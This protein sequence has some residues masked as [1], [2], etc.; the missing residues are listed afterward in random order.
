MSAEARQ[1][2]FAGVTAPSKE[3]SP[4]E[5]PVILPP[6]PS[7]WSQVSFSY[8]HPGVIWSRE[9]MLAAGSAAAVG[10]I[11]LLKRSFSAN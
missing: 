2:T 5:T 10:V 4:E 8:P 11:T 9:L 6:P 3:A 7:W 1:G